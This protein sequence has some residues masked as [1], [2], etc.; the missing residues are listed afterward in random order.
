VRLLVAALAVLAFGAAG[1]A[2]AAASPYGWPTRPP[3]TTGQKYGDCLA[4]RDQQ[5]SDRL[6]KAEPGTVEERGALASLTPAMRSCARHVL[7]REPAPSLPMLRGLIAEQ[8]WLH[9][10]LMV[11]FPNGR[12]DPNGMDIDQ[13]FDAVPDLRDAYRVT[14]CVAIVYSDGVDALIRTRPSSPDERA[15]FEALKP[16]ISTCLADGRSLTLAPPLLR[17]MLA[18]QL[19]R[20]SH[21]PRVPLPAPGQSGTRAGGIHPGS[22]QVEGRG[23]N[24][25]WIPRPSP[26]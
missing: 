23:V 16:A 2:P 25:P 4:A 7:K 20:T 14:T 26:H 22:V 24:G 18:D 5:G 12:L 1:T 9:H 19:Y 15:A 11:G 13:G 10:V 17:A 6:V 3:A 8:L 21:P